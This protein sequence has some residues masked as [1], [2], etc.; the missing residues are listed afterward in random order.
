MTARLRAVVA[1][2]RH[3]NEIY[4]RRSIMHGRKIPIRNGPLQLYS[5]TG[6]TFFTRPPLISVICIVIGYILRKSFIVRSVDG[7]VYL[8]ITEAPC[9]RCGGMVRRHESSLSVTSATIGNWIYHNY[10]HLAGSYFSS[11]WVCFFSLS[12]S[13]SSLSLCWWRPF[14]IAFYDVYGDHS[15]MHNY[16]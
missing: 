3:L 11:D 15:V 7:C 6:R 16:I 4:R 8:N 9:S 1:A 13:S 2:D 10:R 14:C 12:S 5:V